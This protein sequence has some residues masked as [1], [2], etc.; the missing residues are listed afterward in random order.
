MP[1][2]SP[3]KKSL[4]LSEEAYQNIKSHIVSL[5]LAPGSQID[6]VALSESMS[7][8]RTPI[9]EAL[10]R[11]VA[12]NLVE[13]VRGRGFFVR[14]IT[15][16]GIKDLFETMLLME[17]AAVALATR[18]ILAEQIK[19]LLEINDALTAA[20]QAHDFYRTSLLNS[21]F[22]RTIYA[23]TGNALLQNYLDNMQHQSQRLAFICFSHDNGDFDLQSHA[24]MSI[25]D[26]QALIDALEKRDR[27]TAVHI[28]GQHVNLFHRRVLKF[29]Q[30]SLESFDSDDLV[31]SLPAEPLQQKNG[32]QS[33]PHRLRM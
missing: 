28:I 24:R 10:F 27:T 1:K 7:I 33:A 23:A 19:T 13:V 26:H 14:D 9:R 21:R 16:A 25:E 18:R 6:D 12:D 31:A 8:G 22:H 3:R 11:L 20:W 29:T 32:A 17:R 30:P 4:P 5:K 2:K 15:L